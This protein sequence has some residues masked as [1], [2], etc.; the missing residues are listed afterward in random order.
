M[1]APSALKRRQAGRV[2]FPAAASVQANAKER[3]TAR[4]TAFELLGNHAISWRTQLAICE[5]FARPPLKTNSF[6]V[7]HD[8]CKVGGMDPIIGH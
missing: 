8:P 6:L 5:S 4:A 2:C 7:W 1:S 3:S